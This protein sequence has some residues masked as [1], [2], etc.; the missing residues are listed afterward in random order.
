MRNTA[1]APLFVRPRTDAVRKDT[2]SQASLRKLTSLRLVLSCSRIDIS[3]P[4]PIL[5]KFCHSCRKKHQCR[6]S[7]VKNENFRYCHSVYNSM[8]YHSS[9]DEPFHPSWLVLR[10]HLDD[11]DETARK[12]VC[13]SVREDISS[14]QASFSVASVT[15]TRADA[16]LFASMA[17]SMYYLPPMQ[18]LIMSLAPASQ[19][20]RIDSRRQLLIRHSD[21]GLWSEKTHSPDKS[22]CRTVRAVFTLATQV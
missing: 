13:L 9:S 1:R 11:T 3:M 7:E 4:S 18:W 20:A 6:F 8:V 14:L 21:D 16:A 22:P 10:R 17:Y 2:R 19:F 5:D 15:C 12:I